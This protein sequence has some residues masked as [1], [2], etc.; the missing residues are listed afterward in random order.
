MW[1]GYVLRM[2]ET[3]PAKKSFVPN[4]KEKQVGEAEH[5]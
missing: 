4:Q 5:R 3:D 1:V 2:E